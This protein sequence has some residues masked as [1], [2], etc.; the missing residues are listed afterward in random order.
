LGAVNTLLEFGADPAKQT[1]KK[2]SSK[3][4]AKTNDMKKV[5]STPNPTNIHL[6]AIKTLKKKDYRKYN[7][8]NKEFN[9]SK[10]GNDNNNKLQ[11]LNVLSKKNNVN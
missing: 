8:I 6:L 10:R 3:D 5:L 1:N 11:K 2:Q 4:F 7:K 9:R